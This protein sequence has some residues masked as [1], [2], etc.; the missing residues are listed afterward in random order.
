M[1]ESRTV[2]TQKKRTHDETT[3]ETFDELVQKLRGFFD[4]IDEKRMK[5]RGDLLNLTEKYSLNLP[6]EK[7]IFN[8]PIHGHIELHPLLVKIIDTPQFQRLR[9]IKQ[10][11][12]KY[13]VFPGATH[14]R[15]EHSLGVAYLAGCLVKSLQEKQPELNITNRDSLCVQTAALCHD[16]G[17]G[18]FSHLFDGMFI[19]KALPG[20]KWEHEDA[21]IQMFEHMVDQNGL[22]EVMENFDL[23]P[24]EDIPFITKLIQGDKTL[25]QNKSFLFEI[26][27]NKQN[28]IDVDKWDYFV[29]DCYYLGIPNS[30][31]HQRL[32]KSAR[33][34]EVEI[35]EKKEQS[36]CF[37]DKM[38]DN[39]YNMFHTRYTLHRLALQHKTG[40]IIDVMI[41][42]AL[43]EANDKLRPGDKI[44]A[45][46]DNMADYTKLTD[47]IFEKILNFPVPDTDKENPL[48]QA[49][50]ILKNI[51]CRKLP[52]CVG[53]ARLKRKLTKEDLEKSWT[54]MCR[55]KQ[56][57]AEDFDIYVVDMGFGA[58]GKIPVENVFFYNKND[59]NKAF[60]IEKMST[61]IPVK[62][63]EWL[64]RVYYKKTDQEIQQRAENCFREWCRSNPNTD[65]GTVL[66]SENSDHKQLGTQGRI[67]NLKIFNDPIHGH[68]EMHPLLVKI[69]DTPQFQRLHHI[70]QLGGIYL[71]YPG[72]THT[73]FEHSLGM[74]HLARCLIK[75]L[76]ENHEELI[77][78]QESLC[79]QIAALCYNLGHGPFSYLFQRFICRAQNRTE[80]KSKHEE[81]SIL[82]LQHMVNDENN[83]LITEMAK[84]GLNPKEHLPF[85]NSLIKGVDASVDERL[86]DKP[87]L[88]EI[89]ANKKNGIDV[90]RWDYF[91]RDCH[92]L[93]IS[94]SFDHQRLLKS[95]QLCECEDGKKHICFRDK[96]A[97][98]IYN[99]FLTRYT[100][101]RQAYKHRICYIIEDKITESLEEADKELKISDAVNKMEDYTK[102]TDHIYEKILYS[103]DEN[104]EM[105]RTKLE[106]IVKRRLPKF[107]GEDR[108]QETE[109]QDKQA[110]KK[111]LQ[112]NWMT[113]IDNWKEMNS[114]SSLN[115]GDFV[116]HVVY[117]DYGMKGKNLNDNVYVYTKRNPMRANKIN[118]YQVSSILPDK[119]Y[120]VRVRIYYE[121]S[122]NQGE[123]QVVDDAQEKEA[124]AKIVEEAKK[125]FHQWSKVKYGLPPLIMFYEDENFQGKFYRCGKHCSDLHSC[126]KCCNSIRVE[127][128]GTWVLYE[129]PDFLGCEYVLTQGKYPAWKGPKDFGSCKIFFH[130]I[131]LYKTENFEGEPDVTSVDCRSLPDQFSTSEVHSC[132]VLSGV[133]KLYKETDYKGE[134]YQLEEGEYPNHQE[135][136][137]ECPTVQSLKI[138]QNSDK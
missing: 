107:V 39:I 98:D 97:D 32:L 129:K 81:L 49:Q 20:F 116:D 101:Y 16:L 111:T 19:P 52:K 57:N 33:V 128:G 67:C 135:W 131:E 55:E 106:D 66:K 123:V 34:C 87:F 14:T 86:Q 43:I 78:E 30:F 3:N 84:Y 2:S 121:K 26:V 25:Y 119:F 44:S 64:V 7:K 122:N 80:E 54:T 76:Q 130:K 41:T 8:D 115:A 110:L 102:L 6:E 77:T 29:R 35:G 104:L 109:N 71:V 58:V 114:N 53:D 118:R 22:K 132:K 15:F 134:H 100:L 88:S 91:A 17:H 113:A 10:L 68:I 48:E 23:N 46:I 82:M 70:K 79:V 126:M 133:W 45:A 89:V 65:F 73:R 127:G 103:T 85:I 99:M 137:A 124:Q 62:F 40:Y 112:D 24:D 9:Q 69:I 59:P 136:G 50:R 75:V 11:G 47:G 28:G 5:I 60:K 21:S 95:A 61:L 1:S 38:A 4:Q 94:N 56:L 83:E 12:T 92:Y 18:P 31:D 72:A 51:V 36:I 105:A 138:A 74:A 13:L 42:E 125:C 96:V 93:G 63:H 108:L 117:L 27:A 120:E 90:R 37:R